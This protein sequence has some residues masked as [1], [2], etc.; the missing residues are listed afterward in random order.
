MY[1]LVVFLPLLSSVLTGFFGFLIGGKGSVRVSVKLMVLSS[2]LSVIIFYEVAVGGSFCYLKIF[3]WIDLD[4]LQISWRFMFDSL[5]VSLLLAVIFI[6][7]LVHI[8]SSEYMGDDP[9]LVRFMSYI[10]L[11][12]FF[13][14]IL[15][16]SDNFL[17]LFVGWEGVGLCSFLLIN[18]WFTRLQANK[19]AIKAMVTNRVG[20]FSLT[21]GLLSVFSVFKSLEYSLV[22]SIVP[23]FKDLNFFFLNFEIKAITLIGIFFLIGGVGKSAQ[24]GLHIWLPDAM[25]GPTPVSALIHAATMVTAGVFLLARS[26]FLLEY[27]QLTLFIIAIVGSLT[28]FFASTVGLV[29]NDMKRVIAYSTCSQLGYMIFICGLSNYSAGIF[30]LFN[31]AF[32]KALLFL[33]A[34]SVIHSLSDEQDMRRAGGLKNLLPFSYIVFLIGSMSLMGFPFL[35]G[36]YSK[37]LIIELSY[38]NFTF[39]G[40]F[41]FWLGSIS[42]LFTAFYSTRL[43]IYLFLYKT[44]IQKNIFKNIHENSNVVKVSL[45]VLLFGS[46]FI[47]YLFRDIFVGAGTPFWQNSIFSMPGSYTFLSAEFI[48]VYI[49][50]L[51]VIFSILG[52][53]LGFFLYFLYKGLIFNKKFRLFYIFLNRKWFFDKLNSELFLQKF[54]LFCYSIS[55]KLIDKGFLE[56]AGPKGLSGVVFSESKKLSLVQTGLFQHYSFIILISVILMS[57]FCLNIFSISLGLEFILFIFIALFL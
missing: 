10:S 7:T 28:A 53:F 36:F 12:T 46:I 4:M 54:I 56:L 8:F 31:H 34:G 38:C 43:L 22:F 49:K 1:F 40:Y 3:D 51:P 50:L 44:S 26:S 11:F 13:M 37:D 14:L 17:T 48:P 24:M 45:E 19:S 2:L 52:F 15:I 23:Y 9:H 33:G 27:S 6:S 30:H 18:F 57:L 39:K 5:T 16:T 41:S 55:F 42:A 25:E 32:F 47:G 29:Q 35:T 21:L 20:D